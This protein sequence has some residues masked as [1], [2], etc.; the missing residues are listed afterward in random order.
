M[1]HGRRYG[2]PVQEVV[3]KLMSGRDVLLNVDVQGA[4]AVRAAAQHHEPLGSAV[5]TVFLTPPSMAVLEQ[6]LR[7][8]GTDSDQ[9]IQRRLGIARQEIQRAREFDYVLISTTIPE[10]LRRMQSIVE[11]ERM[12]SHRAEIPEV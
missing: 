10:D 11:A 7:S 6:R 5:I 4:A 12:K 3:D 8:R 2:T 1:V 9:A